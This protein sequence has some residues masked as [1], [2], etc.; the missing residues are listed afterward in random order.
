MAIPEISSATAKALEPI[1]KQVE[2][3]GVPAQ[4]ILAIAGVI[5]GA[6][7]LVW[8]GLRI[9][10]TSLKWLAVQALSKLT[11]EPIP[12]KR[13]PRK[14]SASGPSE[15]TG[16]R[17]VFPESG[18]GSVVWPTT[19]T[20][21]VG[22]AKRLSVSDPDCPDCHA[23]LTI[24]WPLMA[25]CP[26]CGTRY[27]IGNFAVAKTNA[28][29]HILGMRNR[30]ELLFP[31]E[32]NTPQPPKNTP[33]AKTARSMPLDLV[34]RRLL[35]NGLSYDVSKNRGRLPTPYCPDPKC[36]T[37]VDVKEPPV[38]HGNWEW[39]CPGCDKFGQYVAP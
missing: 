18:E 32:K 9:T 21:G 17:V 39:S 24:V 34:T 37:K 33:E 6:L 1:I 4:N 36:G 14:K 3:F 28:T 11:G 15:I 22:G 31:G 16:P 12:N 38:P 2:Y 20:V 7:G 19:L 27:K 29:N 23:R 26:T 13:S 25:D 8:L 5:S 10:G 30:G 35:P